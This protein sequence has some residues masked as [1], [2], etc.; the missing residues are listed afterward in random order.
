MLPSTCNNLVAEYV[1]YHH[2]WKWFHKDPNLIKIF[3]L[4]RGIF[5]E[6]RIDHYHWAVES[7]EKVMEF[8]QHVHRNPE[9]FAYF[10][11]MSE[12]WDHILKETNPLNSRD[13]MSSNFLCHIA[14]HASVYGNVALEQYIQ[15]FLNTDPDEPLHVY[16]AHRFEAA[17]IHKNL[18]LLDLDR[19]DVPLLL[20]ILFTWLP[21][22]RQFI[23]TL[24][25]AKE[26]WYLDDHRV[27]RDFTYKGESELAEAWVRG[28]RSQIEENESQGYPLLPRAQLDLLLYKNLL[29]FETDEYFSAVKKRKEAFQQRT[30]HQSPRAVAVDFED[31]QPLGSDM[32]CLIN[33]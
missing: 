14:A 21:S 18:N 3:P 6:L 1:G 9:L 17:I 11:P 7:P 22:R 16:R 26:S 28:L 13:K 33:N 4:T 20:E 32:V 24:L 27:F 29:R 23:I 2:V 19:A 10:R 12:L 30:A 25:E 8:V 5:D 31:I 15:C